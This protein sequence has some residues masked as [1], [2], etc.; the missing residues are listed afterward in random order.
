MCILIQTDH[1]TEPI[2]TRSPAI[3]RHTQHH[4]LD[5]DNGR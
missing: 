2:I 3:G 4:H 1:L 5:W